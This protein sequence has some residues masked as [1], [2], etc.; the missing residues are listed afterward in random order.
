MGSVTLKPIAID[1]TYRLRDNQFWYSSCSFASLIRGRK[2]ILINIEGLG[3]RWLE[4]SALGCD[5]RLTTSFKLPSR[6]DRDWWE[7][8]RGGAV[9]I[10]LLQVLDEQQVQP[11][12]V[13]AQPKRPV[14][15]KVT[16][17]A[18]VRQIKRHANPAT[19]S[20]LCL[21]LDIAWFGGSKT[22]PDSQFDCIASVIRHPDGRLQEFEL[23]RIALANRDPAAEQLA[24]A[25]ANCIRSYAGPKEIVFAIDAPLAAEARGYLPERKSLSGKGEIERRAC[26]TLLSRERQATDKAAGG[27][28]GWHPNIQ[29][30]APVAPR[31]GSLLHHLKDM[32]FKTWS[33]EKDDWKR[34]AIECFPAEAIWALKRLNHYP[35]GL[36]SRDAKAYKKQHRMKLT[37]SEVSHLVSR[38]LDPAAMECGADWQQVVELATNWMLEDAHWQ[39]EGLYRGGKLLDDVVDTML[40]LGTAISFCS[41]GA[42]VWHDPEQPED[43]HIIGPG[44]SDEFD[45]FP[46]HFMGP[47]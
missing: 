43:G 27:S 10:E 3:E 46:V 2:C 9:R 5:G 32:G 20:V 45:W 29:P 33:G 30:G 11:H 4:H 16:T 37:A 35:E 34:L 31:I 18:S 38:V 22:N 14:R 40:C 39:N 13:Q 41:G 36:S 1:E 8:N 42:H 15:T 6:S 12:I 25:V 24:A 44:L 7:A 23:S 47:E 28:E 19:G 21:G 17:A 26:E